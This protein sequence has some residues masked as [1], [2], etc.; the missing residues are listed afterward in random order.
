M[1][2]RLIV[3]NCNRN[4]SPIVAYGLAIANIAGGFTAA[5]ATGG[6]KDDQGNLIVEPVTVFDCSIEPDSNCFPGPL[7]I[8]DKFRD[9]AKTIARDLNQTCV[10]LE[11]DGVVE[12]IGQ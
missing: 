11:I 9:L 7:G 3:P 2:I 5:Q 6:W 12:Y 1:K 4:T 10:Y 8:A